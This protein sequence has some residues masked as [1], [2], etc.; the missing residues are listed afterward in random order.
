M[1]NSYRYFENRKCKYFPCHGGIDNLNCMFCYCPLYLRENCP[2]NPTYINTETGAIKDC[3]AC[4][5]PHK[6]ENYDIVVKLL[7][8]SDK[9]SN[10][11]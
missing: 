1:E 2:G 6:P 10:I 9:K 11:K 8:K 3:S 4:L 7:T 5:F